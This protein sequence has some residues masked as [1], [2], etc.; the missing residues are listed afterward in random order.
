MHNVLNGIYEC[1]SSQ[2]R[3]S[4]FYEP[5]DR[6]N[7]LFHEI[8]VIPFCRSAKIAQRSS[9][10]RNLNPTNTVFY[11]TFGIIFFSIK[12]WERNGWSGSLVKFESNNFLESVWTGMSGMDAQTYITHSS[13]HIILLIDLKLFTHKMYAEKGDAHCIGRSL[14][15]IF[16]FAWKCKI[17]FI[18]FPITQSSRFIRN[19]K[20]KTRL[21]RDLLI[22]FVHIVS[23]S[24]KFKCFISY[25]IKG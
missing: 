2:E 18:C 17:H 10:T 7:K 12:N 5:T 16:F 13:R 25:S 3:L 23:S 14:C 20:R 19:S 15:F 11:E 8:Y 24:S 9:Q 4:I 1:I 6:T 21:C 22:D